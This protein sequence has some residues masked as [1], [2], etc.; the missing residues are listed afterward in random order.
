MISQRITLKEFSKKVKEGFKEGEVL[1]DVRSPEESKIFYIA[2]KNSIQVPLHEIANQA[3][4]L[5]KYDKLYLYCS[6]G[7]RCKT[8]CKILEQKGLENLFYVEGSIGNWI[9]EGLPAKKDQ[10]IILS[11]QR[12]AYALFGVLV[13]S[14]SLLSFVNPY[15]IWLPVA[16]SLGLIA[17]SINGFC[18]LKKTLSR[19]PWNQ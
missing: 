3:Q 19:M 13:L 9:K 4:K 14:G 17:N 2:V 1:V 15:F 10:G 8:A 7:V 11:I 16:V 6:G 5:K 18:Y 12:Q